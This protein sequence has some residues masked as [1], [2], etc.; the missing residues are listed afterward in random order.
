MLEQLARGSKLD[1]GRRRRGP[2][3]GSRAR[4]RL[5]WTSAPP[6]GGRRASGRARVSEL[7]AAEVKPRARSLRRGQRHLNVTRKANEAYAASWHWSRA[8]PWLVSREPMS[9]ATHSTDRPPN[10]SGASL[11]PRG[12]RR[13][14]PARY[15][16]RRR[17]QGPARRRLARPRA[18]SG[19]PAIG[20]DRPLRGHAA[21]AP[22]RRA[23]RGA[24]APGA[25]RVPHRLAG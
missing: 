15:V 5:A 16:C 24:A 2:R 12:C 21:D 10:V 9:T 19:A 1:D 4:E 25:H 13:A 3:A 6:R 17:D 7:A 14:A 22:A 18:R 23:P 11:E 8:A 20:G